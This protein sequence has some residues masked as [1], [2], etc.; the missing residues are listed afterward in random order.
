M[1][2]HQGADFSEFLIGEEEEGEEETP[3]AVWRSLY[4]KRTNLRTLAGVGVCMYVC[5]YVWVYVCMYVCMYV[6]IHVCM[7]VVQ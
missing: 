3:E 5:M 2:I 4:V 7:Y 6:S 1:K